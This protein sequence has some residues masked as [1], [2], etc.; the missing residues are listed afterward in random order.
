MIT[1]RPHQIEAIHAEQ[2]LRLDPT[3]KNTILVLP[4]GGGKSL[5]LADYAR[6]CYE[7]RQ[8]C[9]IFAH[10]DVLISQLSEALCKTGV[11][12]NFI[13]SKR[14]EKEITNHNLRTFGDSYRDSTSPIIVSSNPTFAARIKK[15]RIPPYLLDSC[16]MW[17]QDEC[18]HCLRTSQTWGLCI[19]SLKNAIGIGFT[20]TPKRN[21]KKGLGRNSDGFFDA[22]SVT[23]NMFDLI[24]KGMLVP[25][26]VFIP[27][28]RV[29]R[30][31]LR[32]TQSGD[33]NNDEATKRVDHKEITGDAVAHYLRVS[34]GKPAITFC[35]NIKHAKNVAQQ[36]NEAGVPSIAISSKD[37]QAVR[38]KA[39][40]DFANGTILNLVNVDLLGEGYDCPALTTVIMLRLT[41]SY[42]LFKQQL[43]RALRTAEGKTH[44]II[45]DH[46]GNVNYM[47]Q[48][49]HL[50]NIHDD[51][52]WTLERD[53]K[54]KAA[55]DDGEELDP[56]PLITCPN[57][58][59]GYQYRLSQHP[60]G[61]PECGHKETKHEAEARILKFQQIDADLVE[62]KVDEI[63][64]LIAQRD[65]V[66]KAV[67]AF[68]HSVSGMPKAARFGAIN[69]HAKRSHAQ[70]ILRYHIQQ[71]CIEKGKQTGWSVKLVQTEF[72]RVFHIHILSAQ[73]LGERQAM[74]L[75]ERIKNYGENQ[76]TG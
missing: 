67:E 58:E 61:C 3:V 34:P 76:K 31:G 16:Y 11:P 21:D 45:L 25:Y 42:S 39:M 44:G 5:T 6:R 18:H 73:V 75:T 19:D 37:P 65:H 27:P 41:A 29:T 23:T 47:L 43:G 30:D 53:T 63:D 52:I 69:R 40:A 8:I 72:E 22:M 26:K 9:I 28:T 66:D 70:T 48:T 56:D 17:L 38:D 36:F 33:Y 13:C 12:H 2:R 51:P 64:S 54:P 55:N 68:A 32:V 74:E 14:A 49:Y 4:T 10:R 7:R 50:K 59:C 24:K 62:L 15:G 20:A 57:P 46:V 71:W 35:H 1:L 60:D